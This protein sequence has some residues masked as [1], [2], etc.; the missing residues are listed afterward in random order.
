MPDVYA[1]PQVRARITQFAFRSRFTLAERG[2]VELAAVDDPAAST[3]ARQAA[4]T[5]RAYL[6]DVESA[7][8]VDL[9]RDDVQSGLQQ[10]ESLGLIGAGRAAAIGS[11]IVAPGEEFVG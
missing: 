8:F 1:V 3:P 5:L 7:T 10:L 2:A 4:A 9:T 6:R 11:T